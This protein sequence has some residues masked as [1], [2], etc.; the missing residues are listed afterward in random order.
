MLQFTISLLGDF[1][2]DDLEIRLSTRPEKFI[3]DPSIW[4][5]AEE[6]LREG[7]ETSSLDYK[8]DEGEGTFYGPKIDIKIRDAI[9]RLWQCST[10]QVDF[11]L[12]DRFDLAYIGEDSKRHR[13]V[14]LHRT[15]LG[16]MER[17]FGIL[18]EHYAGAFP[19]WLAP[20]QVAVLTVT[21]GQH[22][23]AREVANA[24]EEKG[25]RVAL[26][27]DSDKL[28]AKIRKARLARIPAIAVVGDREVEQRGVSLRTRASGDI[29][30][31]PLD[32]FLEWM[33][34]ESMEPK[35]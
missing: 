6:S 14:M 22:D 30:F 33:V 19:M 16:S 12:P 15:I 1:G 3:G 2:F 5:H 28:G 32:E 21:D 8:I 24:L 9:G 4:E 20:Q 7:L 35:V 29:G 13:P 17:F 31:K 26:D 25:A 10:I 11:N 27:L 18:I 23:F 34:N